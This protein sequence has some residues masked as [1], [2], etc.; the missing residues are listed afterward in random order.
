[1]DAIEL[2]GRMDPAGE[3]L[4]NALPENGLRVVADVLKSDGESDGNKRGEEN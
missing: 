2:H 3:G 4:N 1:V